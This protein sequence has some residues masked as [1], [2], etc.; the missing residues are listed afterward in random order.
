MK[1]ENIK[2]ILNFLF[3]IIPLQKSYLLQGLLSPAGP[4]HRIG[5]I[6][7]KWSV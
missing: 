4:V 6:L 7:D 1:K 2:D 3:G 5:F